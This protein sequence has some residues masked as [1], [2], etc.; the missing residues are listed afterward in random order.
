M[1]SAV[2]VYFVTGSNGAIGAVHEGI[3]IVWW[4]LV[5]EEHQP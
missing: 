3:L 2:F 4:I 5:Y 1:W